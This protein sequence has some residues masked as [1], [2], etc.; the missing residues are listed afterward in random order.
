RR[1]HWSRIVF[2]G[3]YYNGT[4]E[5]DPTVDNRH[6]SFSQARAAVSGSRSKRTTKAE[7]AERDVA[8]PGRILHDEY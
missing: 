3:N 2:T 4:E 8:S 7:K 1:T 5:D 6:E